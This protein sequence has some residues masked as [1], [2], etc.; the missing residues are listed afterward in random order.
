V[1]SGSGSN[2]DLNLPG[3]ELKSSVFPGEIHELGEGFG[4]LA[5]I[6]I[7]LALRLFDEGEKPGAVDDVLVDEGGGVAEPECSYAV[8][9]ALDRGVDGS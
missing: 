6:E 2:D 4:S 1:A 7:P 3:V 5:V 9:E 8:G